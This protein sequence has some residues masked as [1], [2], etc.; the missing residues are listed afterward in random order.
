MSPSRTLT[1][2]SPPAEVSMADQWFAVATVDHFWIHRRFKVLRQLAGALIQNA[3]DMAEI[4][5]GC[6][7]LQRQIEDSYQRQVT[8]FDL[9]EFAL[10]RNLT[11]LSNIC[12]YDVHQQD[13]SL[14]ERFDLLFLFDVLEH[15]ADEDRFLRSVAFHLKPGGKL[16]VNVPAGMRLHSAYDQAA[17]HVRRYSMRTLQG[18]A[19]RNGLRIANWSYWG[20]PL[21]PML[22]LRKLWLAGKRD[23]AGERE[24]NQI[25]TTGF[26]PRTKT[27]NRLLSLLSNCERI[28]QGLLG[29]SIMAVLEVEVV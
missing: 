4:G 19:A 27:L 11:R 2:L 21:V 22:L 3:G 8:G 26:S 5:C 13:P 15:M 24:K 28:P 17:G 12:C 1:Y 16:I 20:L 14:R 9:N 18:S 6:G 10:R 23:L 7:F 25:I 29:T